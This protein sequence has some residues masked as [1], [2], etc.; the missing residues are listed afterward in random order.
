MLDKRTKQN[1]LV[2]VVGIGLFAVLMN[3]RMVLDLLGEVIGIVLPIIAGSILALFI[4]VPMNGVKR[5]IYRLT[6]RRKKKPGAKA[7]HITAFVVTMIC[8]ITILVLVLTMLV[9]EI[10]RSS[11]NLYAQV[12]Q[13]LP[14]WIAYLEAEQGGLLWLENL[15]AEIDM[16]KVMQSISD[17]VDVLLPN[18]ASVL[19][20]TISVVIT[21]GFAI[22]V[23]IYMSLGTERVCRHCSKLVRAYLK[24]QWA[25]KIQQFCRVFYQFFSSFLSGQCTEAVILGMLMFFAFAIFRLPYAS[26]VGVLTAVCAIVPYVGA[27][28]SC[29]VSIFLTTLLD[30][31]LAIRCAIVYLAVQFI[32]NQFIYPRVV[33][34]SVG[35]PPFYTLL[36]AMIG[37]KLFGIIG[38]IFFIPL[39]AVIIELVKEDVDLR[40]QKTEKEQTVSHLSEEHEQCAEK[41]S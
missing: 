35:L 39:L 34:E 26:L 27:F 4:S 3:L 18:V 37:G 20:S 2:T 25:G 38:I 16:D 36:A 28:I 6:R 19:S 22:I 23:S 21:S 13:K 32:E 40:L 8:V 7:V 5:L 29:T 30:P 24:P 1:L 31:T 15:L 11:Q 33:G 17:G 14:E 12:R 41:N 10:V 9:P